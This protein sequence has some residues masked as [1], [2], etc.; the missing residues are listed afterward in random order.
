MSRATLLILTVCLIGPATAV[1][2][3]S[4]ATTGVEVTV[5]NNVAKSQV[6][7]DETSTLTVFI[8]T[9]DQQ[10]LAP[11]ETSTPF[12]APNL[13]NQYQ[14][15][16][17]ENSWF[18]IPKADPNHQDPDNAGMQ[19]IISD[20][21]TCALNT[22][23]SLAGPNTPDARKVIQVEGKSTGPG[24]CTV[25]VSRLSPPGLYPTKD[26][27]APP[28]FTPNCQTMGIKRGQNATKP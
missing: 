26:C 9:G 16:L 14:F 12:Q 1:A 24:Q 8:T 15:G 25:T 28:I 27:C 19:V 10:N 18:W 3:G 21:A 11:G 20:P 5:V 2:S 13:F 22:A 6:C 7:T 23:A 4:S 17:Q